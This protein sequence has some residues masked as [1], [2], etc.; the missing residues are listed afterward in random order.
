MTSWFEMVYATKALCGCGFGVLY[1]DVPL[2]DVYQVEKSS[3]RPGKLVCG[4]CG[5]TTEVH[6]VKVI[7]KRPPGGHGWLP[8]ELFED[9]TE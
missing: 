3:V 1:D 2:G 6:L 8:L 7:N 9:K 5:K 4:Q